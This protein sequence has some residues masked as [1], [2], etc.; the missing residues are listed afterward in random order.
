MPTSALLESM[1][2]SLDTVNGSP[3]GILGNTTARYTK[4]AAV[5]RATTRN[6]ERQ[7]SASP[8]TRPSGMPTMVATDEPVTTMPSASEVN[9]S[10]TRRTAMGEAI[11]QNT[12]W[13]IAT[14]MRP[15]TSIA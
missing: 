2:G 10:G 9:F 5:M 14:T 8:T 15:A 6:A 1:R 13:P 3:A 4:T 7:P 11:D 12:A